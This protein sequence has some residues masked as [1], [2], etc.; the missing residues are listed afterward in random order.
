MV[1]DL[2]PEFRAHLMFSFLSINARGVNG[3]AALQ[4]ISR[5]TILVAPPGMVSTDFP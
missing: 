2:G 5:K 1:N 4:G 3:R